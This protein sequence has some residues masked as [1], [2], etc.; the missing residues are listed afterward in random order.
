MTSFGATSASVA[1]VELSTARDKLS[2]A[3][4][5]ASHRDTQPATDLAEQADV[6]A[7]LAEA[8][9]RQHKSHKAAEA[10]M[11]DAK[12]RGDQVAVYGPEAAHHS[13]VRA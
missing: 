11:Y 9:A 10:A 2:S 3:E 1:P 5:A 7:Q 8:T 6:D 13:P 4:Q 12:Q